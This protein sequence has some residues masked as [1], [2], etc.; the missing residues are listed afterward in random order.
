MTDKPS[1]LPSTN[2]IADL[3]DRMCVLHEVVKTRLEKKGNLMKKRYD[4]KASANTAHNVGDLVMIR[5]SVLQN[6]E[7]RK[8][9]LSYCVV[10]VLPPVHY[11]IE[12]LNGSIT[13]RVRF[14][15]LE[16]GKN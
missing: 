4:Q 7:S 11:V 12:S 9:Y 14:N 6:D 2:S 13:K 10:E 5:N 3:Q 16:L 1:F 8:F 15:C